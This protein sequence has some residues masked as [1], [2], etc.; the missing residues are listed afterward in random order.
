MKEL[1]VLHQTNFSKSVASDKYIRSN[2]G[3]TTTDT[4]LT[5]L[6]DDIALFYVY[7]RY[8]SNVQFKVGTAPENHFYYSSQEPITWEN[9]LLDRRYFVDKLNSLESKGYLTKIEGGKRSILYRIHFIDFEEEVNIPV[10]FLTSKKLSWLSKIRFFKLLLSLQKNKITEITYKPSLNK[11]VNPFTGLTPKALT[12]LIKSMQQAGYVDIQNN[13]IN[14]SSVL[15][16]MHLD[17]AEQHMESSYELSSQLVK[18]KNSKRLMSNEMKL[19]KEKLNHKEH[20]L[21]ELSG[22]IDQQQKL[23]SKFIRGKRV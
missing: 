16:N 1:R 17:I 4:S 20:Q 13:T 10:L 21:E 5:N 14:T 22:T 3:Y 2:K 18:A 7:I 23:I 15:R 6:S 19:L 9:I 11:S 8:I 12:E